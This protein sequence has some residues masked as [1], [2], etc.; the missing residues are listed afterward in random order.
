MNTT[1]DWM[2]GGESEP[3]PSNALDVS[4]LGI[5]ALI[6]GIAVLADALFLAQRFLG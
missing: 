3:K 4:I 2:H 6:A 1:P 5:V